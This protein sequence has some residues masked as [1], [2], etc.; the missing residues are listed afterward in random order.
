MPKAMSR[1]SRQKLGEALIENGLIDDLQLR[2]AL[3]DQKR[4]GNRLG[5]TLVKLGF[6]D[7]APLMRHLSR[8]MG[9][10]LAELRGRE[11]ESEVLA[12]VPGE[13]AE[14]LRC[15]PLFVDDDG[16]SR[17]LYLGM[18]EPDDLDA[19]ETLQLRLGLE[20]CPALIAPGELDAGLRRYYGVGIDGDAGSQDEAFEIGGGPVGP[21]CLLHGDD[22]LSLAAPAAAPPERVAEEAAASPVQR[23]EPPGDGPSRHILQALTQLLLEKGVFTR[24]ELMAKIRA[25]DGAEH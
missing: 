16:A 15:L 1:R 19:I 10:P 22:A 21:D 24:E 11:I 4:W 20:L 14:K 12:L 9:Y 8:L 5:K 7:E 23:A 13:L 2:S 18:D 17:Y 25:L 6:I 3:A